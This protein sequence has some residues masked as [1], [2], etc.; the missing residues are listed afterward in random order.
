[1]VAR[2]PGESDADYELRKRDHRYR[3]QRS[4]SEES[5]AAAPAA[6]SGPGAAEVAAPVIIVEEEEEKE[7][8]RDKA[9]K[10]PEKPETE[11]PRA[12]D[13]SLEE[14]SQ[15]QV[16]V[17]SRVT[18]RSGVKTYQVK[19]L[20]QQSQVQEGDGPASRD[21]S[22]FVE[23]LRAPDRGPSES[24]PW[25]RFQ[26][27]P[28]EEQSGQAPGV[29]SEHGQGFRL[30]SQQSRQYR[31]LKSQIRLAKKQGATVPG[32]IKAQVE[33][34]GE[35]RK[36][37]KREG[38][39]TLALSKRSFRPAPIRL[40]SLSTH[41]IRLRSVARSARPASSKARPKPKPKPKPKQP[42]RNRIR[43]PAK[44][45]LKVHGRA[46]KLNKK[47]RDLADKWAA[48]NALSPYFLE[49]PY[50]VR[51]LAVRQLK[52]ETGVKGT[53]ASF[54]IKQLWNLP[55]EGTDEKGPSEACSSCDER[56]KQ[57]EPGVAEFL[58]KRAAEKAETE[59][60]RAKVKASK[61]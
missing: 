32:N 42:V 56:G 17:G 2:E 37:Y 3:R 24:A 45:W 36:T 33:E 60:K 12:R 23:R 19:G 48:D 8:P 51:N 10:S 46:L 59:A 43:G 28:Q 14:V 13:P 53:V 29:R 54:L 39:R 4:S 18:L 5:S 61:P 44:E 25:R 21:R 6:S 35:G 16:E 47:I 40:R 52:R 7:T 30:R 22:E 58:R 15:V 50:Q 9:P 41:T 49:S 34:F 26:N 55:N 27:L 38:G 20:H 57:I 11:R 1:M 31:A